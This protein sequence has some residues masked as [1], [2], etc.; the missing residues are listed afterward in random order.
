MVGI[1][2]NML[3]FIFKQQHIASVCLFLASN[4]AH[5]DKMVNFRFNIYENII[6]QRFLFRVKYTQN[7]R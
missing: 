2:L 3:Y 4:I 6:P 7:K 5:N 1:V